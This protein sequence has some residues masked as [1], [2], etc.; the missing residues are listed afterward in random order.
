MY[1][2]LALMGLTQDDYW[3]MPIGLLLDLWTV[4]KQYHGIEKP[5][6]EVFIDDILMGI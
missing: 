1:Y 2:S 4:H 5:Y 3:L 6:K